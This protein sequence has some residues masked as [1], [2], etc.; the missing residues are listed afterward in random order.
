MAD[1]LSEIVVDADALG[2]RDDQ[3]RCLLKCC[4]VLQKLSEGG[5]GFLRLHF[6]SQATSPLHETSAQP[7]PPEVLEAPVSKVN[8]SP[9]GSAVTGS[10]TP[11]RRQLS[12]P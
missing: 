2:V 5:V 10:S 4:G 8:H 9:L 12:I 1:G 11:K 7:S 6:Y 3:N